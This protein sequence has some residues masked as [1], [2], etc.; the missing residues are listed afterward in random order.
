M[1]RTFVG[2]AT[3]KQRAHVAASGLDNQAVASSPIRHC[4]LSGSLTSKAIWSP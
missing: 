3:T 1:T 4:S 2:V